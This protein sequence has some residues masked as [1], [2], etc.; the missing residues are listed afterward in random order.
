MRSSGTL[1]ISA[2]FQ[3]VS[4]KLGFLSTGHTHK[5]ISSYVIPTNVEGKQHLTQTHMHM[6]LLP[7]I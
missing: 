6:T 2:S 4:K 3:Q 1:S 7:E 5:L